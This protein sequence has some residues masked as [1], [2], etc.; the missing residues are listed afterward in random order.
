[1]SLAEKLRV[2]PGKRVDLT[3]WKTDA[4]PGVKDEATAA[5]E[6]AKH[7]RQIEQYQYKLHAEGRRS[8]LIVLQGMDASGKDGVVRHVMSGFDPLGCDVQA[9]KAPTPEERAHDFLWRI[10]RV[11]PA[12]GGVTIFNRSHYEDVLV[13]RVHDLVPK[14]VWSQRYALINLFED[15]LASGGTTVVKFFLHIGRAEQKRRLLARLDDPEKRWK[16]NASDIDERALWK[17]YREAY[18]TVLEQCS[19]KAAPWYVIPADQKW[20]RDYAISSILIDTF[21]AIDPQVPTPPLDLKTLRSRLA[22]G[23]SGRR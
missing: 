12:G 15:L 17:Q 8:L 5:A 4:T 9:F 22:E 10:H 13:V 21:R 23:P 6:T 2:K 19:S 20:Y 18:E 7:V 11:A 16:F 14:K 3:D 1:M